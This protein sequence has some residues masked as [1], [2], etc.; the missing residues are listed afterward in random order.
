MRRNALKNA[1]ALR[2]CID[3]EQHA[4]DEAQLAEMGG[5]IDLLVLNGRYREQARSH[6]EFRRGPVA[7]SLD[8]LVG[9]GLLT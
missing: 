3:K 6:M 8:R 2:R 9:A 1:K 4:L 5:G 7:G